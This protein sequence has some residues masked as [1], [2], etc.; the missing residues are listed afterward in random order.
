MIKNKIDP[1]ILLDIKR[2][3]ASHRMN[4]V[5]E[6]IIRTKKEITAT[7]KAE[8]ERNGGKISS[9]IGDIF[10]AKIPAQAISKIA[11]LDFVVYIEKAK[12]QQLE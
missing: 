2:L 3:K 12:K 9:V 8:I 4:E 1:S 7:E 10:T 6:V 11:N 5:I